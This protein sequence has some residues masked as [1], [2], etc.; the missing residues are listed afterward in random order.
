VRD[1]E[2]RDGG[3]PRLGDLR[4]AALHEQLDPPL[5]HVE[6]LVL[7]VVDVRRRRVAR[8]GGRDPISMTATRPPVCSPATWTTI[9]LRRNHSGSPIAVTPAE[10][11]R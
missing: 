1:A 5:Q 4:L 9:R 8:R 6:D 2:R 3:A 7:L 10:T 11:T